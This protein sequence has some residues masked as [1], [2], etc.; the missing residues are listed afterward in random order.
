MLGQQ[1]NYT[2]AM[3]EL[4]LVLK[5][6]P[7]DERAQALMGEYKTRQKE[8]AEKAHQARQMLV[9]K[10]FAQILS[11]HSDSELF[12]EHS[13]KTEKKASTVSGTILSALRSQAPT[14]TIG[15]NTTPE[16]D[17]TAIVAKQELGGAARI[18]VIAIGQTAAD[19][20][21]IRYKLLEYKVQAANLFSI[22]ALINMPVAKNY[23]PLHSTR[24]GQMTDKMRAQIDDGVKNMTE[25]IMGA[26]G[27]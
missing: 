10:A 22:G 13:I 21:E 15:S 27:Q 18:C 7:A 5:A 9:R 3:R 14:F 26:I 4:E 17:V 12:V 2:A 24:V 1:G 25:R 19:E 23:I 20:T 6:L 11:R 8:E 16:P